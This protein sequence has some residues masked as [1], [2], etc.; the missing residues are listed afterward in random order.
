VTIIN[1][2]RSHVQSVTTTSLKDQSYTITGTALTYQVPEFTSDPA[3]CTLTYEYSLSDEALASAIS[4]DSNLRTFTFESSNDLTLSGDNS[5]DYTVTIT[6]T[7]GIDTPVSDS[8]SFSI[9]M[10]NP[11]IDESFVQINAPTLAN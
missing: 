5:I 2:C 11:C 1:P 6:A 7:A 9:Q 10:K 3:W 8:S 4:Y